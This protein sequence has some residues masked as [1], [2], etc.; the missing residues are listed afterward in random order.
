MLSLKKTLLNFFDIKDDI[1]YKFLKLFIYFYDRV[2]TLLEHE[3]YFTNFQTTKR[4][5]L[6][7][8]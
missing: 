6:N 4:K 7:S 8:K 1:I 2:L 5:L 3:G